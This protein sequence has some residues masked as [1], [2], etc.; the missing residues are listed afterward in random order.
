MNLT[1]QQLP[2]QQQR[3]QQRK[4]ECFLT[5]KLTIFITIVRLLLV[6]RCFWRC[7]NTILNVPDSTQLPSSINNNNI[8]VSEL[9]HYCTDDST[10][11]IVLR[12]IL[13]K[14]VW[15]FEHVFEADSI[16][17]LFYKNTDDD[18]NGT[19]NGF[20]LDD[21]TPTISLLNNKNTDSTNRPNQ[22]R[23]KP[24]FSDAYV[25]NQ[26]K[27]PPLLLILLET[28]VYICTYYS[29]P[30]L[31]TF[32]KNI[33][34]YHS[35]S[36]SNINQ[37]TCVDSIWIVLVFVHLISTIIDLFIGYQMEQFV[38]KSLLYEDLVNHYQPYNYKYNTNQN[39]ND[40]DNNNDNNSD[41][42]VVEDAPNT[43]TTSQP[44]EERSDMNSM[45][46]SYILS[47][48]DQRIYPE[49][50]HIFPLYPPTFV[51]PPPPPITITSTT[52]SVNDHTPP[53]QQSSSS[54]T[55]SS[56]QIITN[57]TNT[58]VSSKNHMDTKHSILHTNVKTN[59]YEDDDNDDD[60]WCDIPQISINTTNT[61]STIQQ[62]AAT[63]ET[64]EEAHMTKC[65]IDKNDN[66]MTTRRSIQSTL[67][68]WNDL[69]YF[70]AQ[71]YYTSPITVMASCLSCTIGSFQN[72]RV[73]LLLY[74][75][76]QLFNVVVVVD[77]KQH[78]QAQSQQDVTN[79][80]SSSNNSK[81]NQAIKPE[82][83]ETIPKNTTTNNNS[84]NN[85][86]NHHQHATN[87]S[88]SSYIV[89]A[90]VALAIASYIDIHIHVFAI[91][92]YL[93]LSNRLITTTTIKTTA[94]D[95]STNTD[96]HNHHH[97]DTSYNMNNK[98]RFIGLFFVT[99]YLFYSVSFY[100]LDYVLL[101]GKQ[102][103]HNY[104]WY[105]VF[106]STHFHS[107]P[108]YNQLQPSTT[109]IT[110]PSLSMIWYVGMEVFEQFRLYFT[111]LLNGISSVCIIVPII[112]RLYRYPIVLVTILYMIHTIFQSPSTLYEFNV[113]MC[114]FLISSSRVLTRVSKI[115]TSI[116]ICAI[117]IPISLYIVSYYMWMK[118]NTGEA[119]FVYFQC[120]VY[121]IFIGMLLLLFCAASLRR[122]KA[123]RVTVKR[124]SAVAT[125]H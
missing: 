11:S 18:D 75:F 31:L 27:L 71:L 97:H 110:E 5:S 37:N 108:L 96:N 77:Q 28:I 82:T 94:M 114:L 104:G 81:L 91:P 85:T 99:C 112:I 107:F 68:Q 17:N 93:L 36:S 106:I 124:I 69:P 60:M 63:N 61:N 122:D 87:Q 22:N 34:N 123:I 2:Q 67:F 89:N 29:S 95:H 92:A 13:I 3:Q 86:N 111:I 33:N 21:Q 125:S 46:E 8:P 72:V 70:I 12:S 24:S 30:S 41:K 58:S 16:R 74:S 88:S 43:T 48:M 76:N 23:S 39:N 57:D 78:Q 53:K 116:C 49:L 54:S 56:F 62:T 55:T 35:S 20:N 47:Q 19:N 109:T 59:Q 64:T 118:T 65:L 84:H 90:S 98:K 52:K 1:S 10:S 42:L 32:L 83:T 44:T 100:T 121:N 4:Q 105:S 80:D 51:L 117:P 119:N 79:D 45:N 73:L 7:Y 113:S 103:Q 101:V 14:P 38:Q 25:G 9:F 115:I 40:D 15:T 6:Y 50:L 102:Q 66:E 120:L 26:I